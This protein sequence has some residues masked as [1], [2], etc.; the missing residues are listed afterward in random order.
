VAECPQ[1]EVQMASS[2]P[3]RRRYLHQ[4]C[5]VAPDC[6]L[7]Y[8]VVGRCQALQ[9]FLYRRLGRGEQVTDP[10][11]GRIVD[12]AFPRI[13]LFTTARIHLARLIELRADDIATTH[14][15]PLHL[16]RA[17]VTMATA[18]TTTNTA[19]P[20]RQVAL[21][22]TGGD[23][24]QRLDRLLVPPTPLTAPAPGSSPPP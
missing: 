14:N 10:G 18:T 19:N 8:G 20:S 1:L 4:V 3:R 15:S 13:A 6:G 22:A 9:C 7:R 11:L 21:A 5:G 16:A 17:L 2:E 24:M 23:A 12:A